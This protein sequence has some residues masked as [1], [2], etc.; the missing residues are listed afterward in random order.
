MK[1]KILLLTFLILAIAVQAERTLPQKEMLE[2]KIETNDF[3]ELT[4][5]DWNEIRVFFEKADDEQKIKLTF[6]FKSNS[7]EINH[8]TGISNLNFSLESKKSDLENSISTL[9]K[10]FKRLSEL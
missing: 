10:T 9:K 4:N 5:I 2:F 1:S 3:S 7:K 6:Y 8:D